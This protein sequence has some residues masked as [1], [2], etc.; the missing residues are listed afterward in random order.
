MAEREEKW[1]AFQ[2][3]LNGIQKELR[4]K[5]MAHWSLQLPILFY[6]PQPSL[7]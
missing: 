1:P 4:Q 2:P 6:N 3:T 5:K 7:K